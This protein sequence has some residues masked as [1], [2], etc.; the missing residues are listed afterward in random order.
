[1]VNK[2]IH[3]LDSITTLSSDDELAIYDISE[4]TTKRGIIENILKTDISELNT[5]AN[6]LVGAINQHETAINQ[7]KTTINQHEVIINQYLD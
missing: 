5:T 6:N 7:N 2:T 4:S 1:M 3:E